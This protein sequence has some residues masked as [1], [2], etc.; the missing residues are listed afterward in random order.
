L[1]TPTPPVIL[2]AQTVILSVVGV[3]LSVQ[4]VILSV[5]GVILSVVE[6]SVETPAPKAIPPQ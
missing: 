6:G 5:V 1:D 4:T 3:I 2:S